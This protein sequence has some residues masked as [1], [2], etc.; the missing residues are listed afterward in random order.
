M[1]ERRRRRSRKPL[2]HLET[3][4][5]GHRGLPWLPVAHLRL[6]LS[7]LAR[8]HIRRIGRDE[9]EPAAGEAGQQV[10]REPLHVDREPLPI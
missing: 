9:L 7:D 5:A 2:D 4:L 3:A 8:R 10:G 6:E 1:V